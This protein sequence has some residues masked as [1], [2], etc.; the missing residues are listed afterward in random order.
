MKKISDVEW[1]V[2]G[3]LSFADIEKEYNEILE[4]IRKEV[5]IPGFRKGRAPLHI[6]ESRF[7]DRAKNDAV[8]K[9]IFEILKS[10]EE[11]LSPVGIKDLVWNEKDGKITFSVKVEVIPRKK[12]DTKVKVDVKPEE[13]QVKDEEIEIKYKG[14][15]TGIQP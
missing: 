15:K 2:E 9:K 1:Q 3:E 7:G 11:W 4:E 8:G 5:D 14:K 10:R 13:I 12:I 6:V